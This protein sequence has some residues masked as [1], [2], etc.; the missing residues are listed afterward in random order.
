ME[1][2]FRRKYSRVPLSPMVGSVLVTCLVSH[3]CLLKIIIVPWMKKETRGS[4]PPPFS[5]HFSFSLIN[6]KR[7]RHGGVRG[8]LITE[9]TA[10]NDLRSGDSPL[11]L[12]SKNRRTPKVWTKDSSILEQTSHL[13]GC[14]R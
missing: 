6:G 5:F 11:G 2:T 10:R 13:S 9:H 3:N 12:R 1:M 8:K 4:S 14:L 7:D